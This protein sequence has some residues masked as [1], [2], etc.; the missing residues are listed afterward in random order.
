[1]RRARR[2]DLVAESAVVRGVDQRV[3]VG[4]VD[5]LQTTVRLRQPDSW[6]KR[7]LTRQARCSPAVPGSSRSSA[8]RCTCSN[9]A[10]CRRVR[11]GRAGG[12]AA[13][14]AYLRAR[15][16]LPRRAPADPAADVEADRDECPHRAVVAHLPRAHG[17]LGGDR[18][19]GGRPLLRHVP[20]QPALGGGARACGRRVRVSRR[21]RAEMGAQ[22]RGCG[23]GRPD[24]GE[25]SRG[26]ARGPQVRRGAVGRAARSRAPAHLRRR[27]R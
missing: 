15:A 19:R 14:L 11:C 13:D 6:R 4:A 20:R 7:V 18:A 12:R 8:A 10:G 21:N 26:R 24:R 22:G 16:R 5:Q 27:G 9:R 17:A 23:R 2:G 1:M 25:S 3:K